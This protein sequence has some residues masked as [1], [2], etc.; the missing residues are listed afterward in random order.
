[1]KNKYDLLAL[2]VVDIIK[3]NLDSNNIEPHSIT[4]N[5]LDPK[6]LKEKIVTTCK[7]YM[8]LEG[9]NDIA[10]VRLIT[11]FPSDVDKII[12]IIKQ[13]LS[14]HSSAITVKPL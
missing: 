2:K 13:C 4:H 3:S 11:Y 6:V 5:V 1:M 12:E 10:T 14:I 8:S 9:I 7:D